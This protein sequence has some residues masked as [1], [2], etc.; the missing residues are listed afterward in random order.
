MRRS[1]TPEFTE[2]IAKR[3]RSKEIIEKK[4]SRKE[5]MPRGFGVTEGGKIIRKDLS[6]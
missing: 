1:K 3:S 6:D 4:I 5:A 2:N